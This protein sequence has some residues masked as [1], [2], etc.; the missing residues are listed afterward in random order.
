MSYLTYPDLNNYKEMLNLG[1]E[2][3]RPIHDFKGIYENPE[4]LENK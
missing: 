4:L 1:G 2:V 3:W